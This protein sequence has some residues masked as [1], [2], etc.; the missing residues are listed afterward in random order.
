VRYGLNFFPSFRLSDR[1]TAEYYDQVLRLAERGDALGYTSAKCVE[2]YFHDYGGHTPSPIVLLAAIA[3]RT[4]QLRPITGAVIPSFS[5]PI[6]LAG[7]LAM[8]DNLCQGRLDVGFGRAFIPDEF[9]AFGVDMDDSRARF[10]EA[11]EVI[12]RLWTEDRVTH[13]GRFFDL[14]NIHLTPR[15]V[16][17]PHPPVWIAAI[18]TESSFAAAGTRGQHVML[19]PY[20]GDLA[21]TAR[22]LKVYQDAW[23][24]AGHPPGGGRVQVSIH[25]YLAETHAEALEGFK[26]PINRYIEVFSEAM[27]SWDGRMSGSYAG[28]ANIVASIRSQTPQ[29]MLDGHV[30]LVGTP[31]EAVEELRYLR[32]YLGDFEPSMQISFGGM[33]DAEAFRTL[34]LFATEVA[35]HVEEPAAQPLG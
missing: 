32:S 23:D 35:P 31:S 20:A 18:A 3:A 15:P 9:D 12:V 25:V 34:E 24:A 6:K 30:A 29:K 27:N 16:Q 33:S 5:H 10:E 19:V 14:E 22:L 28:Y 4:R 7:E 13:H 21:G 17:Q 11:S 1:S 26:R 2:H 8:L